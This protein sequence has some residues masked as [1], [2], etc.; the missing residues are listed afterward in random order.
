[1]NWLTSGILSFLFCRC[2]MKKKNNLRFIHRSSYEKKKSG[3][4]SH[5]FAVSPTFGPPCVAA[6]IATYRLMENVPRK[7]SFSTAIW[8]VWIV[9]DGERD[10]LVCA[11]ASHVFF[12]FF[13]PP[14]RERG[15]IRTL[16]LSEWQHNVS[17]SILH[18]ADA[19]STPT[20]AITLA[21]RG[22]A[23]L[24][25]RSLAQAA[26]FAM[27]SRGMTVWWWWC[28]AGRLIKGYGSF[29]DPGGAGG[30]KSR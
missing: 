2:C 12:V 6:S 26:P 17:V 20:Q 8:H 3:C 29:V 18:L 1:M 22:H 24:A 9:L 28:G 14:Q 21:S 23:K 7:K 5:H 13:S 11:T 16:W 25:R 4:A 19:I 10:H 30:W 27:S 15:F